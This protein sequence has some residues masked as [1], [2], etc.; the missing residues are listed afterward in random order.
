MAVIWCAVCPPFCYKSEWES[1]RSE[2]SSDEGSWIRVDDRSQ[3]KF[4]LC[5]LLELSVLLIASQLRKVFIQRYPMSFL[6]VGLGSLG[7]GYYGNKYY[8]A[9]IK[10]EHIRR[11]VNEKLDK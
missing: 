4:A 1:K 8:R 10:G 2:A 3:Q 5:S 6:I 11:F 9:V 7:A